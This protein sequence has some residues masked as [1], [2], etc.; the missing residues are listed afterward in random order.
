M[1]I[2]YFTTKFPYNQQF[3][4]YSYGGSTLAAYYLL[5][6]MA[7]RGNEIDVFTTSVNSKD[8]VEKHENTTIY[9]YGTN[10]RVLTS[11]I[12][13]G[14]FR[15]P[16][17]HDVDVAHEHFDIPHG[18]F[19]GLRYAKRKNVPLVVTYHGDW[20]E[21]YGGFIRRMGVAFHNRYLVDKLLS[22]AK[23]IISPSEYYINE[24]RFLK[25]YRDKIVAIPN[26]VNL[27]DFN[28][29]YSKKECRDR[30]GIP[31]NTNI[32]LFVGNLISYKGP[33]VLVKAIPIIT[34][35]VP[36]VEL[37]FVGS[38]EMRADVE[39]LSNK[40]G[41]ENYI[42]FAGFVEERLKPLYYK[43]ADVF[44]LPS[45]MSTESFGIVNL[46]AMACSIP[47]VASNIGGIPDVV[48]E[49]ENGLLV[50]PRDSDAL[51]NAIIY[52]LENEG[53]RE[54]MG[55][56]GRKKVKDYSWEQVAEMTEKVYKGV[57]DEN[58]CYDP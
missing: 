15:N 28:V 52:L 8:S 49:G 35:K 37:V 24:S 51:A 21:S 33:D 19:A 56:N 13:F 7:K 9:R 46:E 6:E 53:A 4:Q 30:L 32:I 18:I 48:K 44:C 17:N 27:K 47:I 38:G 57:M 26:G 10:F 39:K 54:K 31:L 23:I 5:I 41:V 25:K 11:N 42:K 45:T 58:G 55:K 50:P 36:D 16:V 1:K 22:H 34:R 14:T 3:K 40:L 12:S 20:E 2:G 43:A 29:P